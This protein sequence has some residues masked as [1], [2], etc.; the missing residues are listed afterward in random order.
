MDV[1]RE[2]TK[3]CYS[4]PSDIAMQVFSDATGISRTVSYLQLH[5]AISNIDKLLSELEGANK[6]RKYGLVMENSPE[7]VV[8]DLALG[9]RDRI[10]VPVPNMF[11]AEQAKNL[12]AD[13][14][15]CLVD[16]RNKSLLDTWEKQWG[17]PN[18]IRIERSLPMH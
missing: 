5:N 15:V 12:L 18:K 2:I 6:N 11:N 4:K 16:E 3:Y 14:D 8:C 10:L 9:L 17:I 7:W 13:V 1:Y